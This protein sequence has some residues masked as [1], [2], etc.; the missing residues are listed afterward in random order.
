[1]SQDRATRAQ[2]VRAAATSAGAGALLLWVALSNWS[3]PTSTAAYRFVAVLAGI[4][5]VEAFGLAI[6]LLVMPART[7]EPG[8][9]QRRRTVIRATVNVVCCLLLAFVLARLTLSS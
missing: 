2:T 8:P 1:M 9:A 5:S 4:V 7:R 3:N 6:W